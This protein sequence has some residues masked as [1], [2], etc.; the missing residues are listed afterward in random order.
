MKEKRYLLYTSCVKSV[1]STLVH[2]IHN[3]QDVICS[4]VTEAPTSLLLYREPVNQTILGM[5]RLQPVVKRQ[6]YIIIFRWRNFHIRACTQRLLF[7]CV[8]VY[9]WMGGGRGGGGGL[10]SSWR[11]LFSLSR[12][13]PPSPPDKTHRVCLERFTLC[14]CFTLEGN[15][16][17]HK[18]TKNCFHSYLEKYNQTEEQHILSEM[19]DVAY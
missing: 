9:V 10:S 2:C 14:V 15:R 13:C 16:F 7:V 17:D 11:I 8:C 19:C 1:K 6:S 12:W 3:L 18:E 4:K 5:S